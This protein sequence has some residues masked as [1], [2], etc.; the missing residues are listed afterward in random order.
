MEAASVWREL[1]AARIRFL[2]VARNNH[3]QQHVLIAIAIA[4]GRQQQQHRASR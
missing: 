4:R 3:Q 2:F 1:S